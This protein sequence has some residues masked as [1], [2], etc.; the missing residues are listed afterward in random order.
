M[1][2]KGAQQFPSLMLTVNDHLRFRGVVYGPNGALTVWTVEFEGMGR[3]EL[4]ELIVSDQCSFNFFGPGLLDAV[5]VVV[6]ERVRKAKTDGYRAISYVPW[7]NVRE[8]AEKTLA[9]A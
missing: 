7:E 9:K 5:E 2:K 8:W 6:P 4:A 1:T 3:E